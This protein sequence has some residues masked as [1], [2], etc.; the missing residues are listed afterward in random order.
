V[1]DRYDATAIPDD[2]IISEG[3]STYVFTVDDET[4][5]RTEVETGNSVGSLT[6]I[7]EG[8]DTD[9][10]VVVAGWDNLSDGATV[11]IDEDFE[12]EA[13]N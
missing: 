1:L 3:L 13:L 4:A 11:E 10:R 6:E 8:L 2:A 7:R 12:R 5:R 9:D